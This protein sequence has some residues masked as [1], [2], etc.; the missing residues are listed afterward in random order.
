MPHTTSTIQ[1]VLGEIKIR[2]P[3]FKPKS[4]L[5]YGAG[6]GAGVFAAKEIYPDSL[7]KMGA[8]EPNVYMRKLGK[9]LT[10]PVEPEVMWVDAL[11]MLPGMASA[12]GQ[13]YKFDIIIMAYVLTEIP[14]PSQR[15]IVLET[16]MSRVK[17]NGY[18]VLLE[19]GSPKGFRY[20]HD[21]RNIVR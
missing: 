8:V 20:I 7:N 9:F 5:D 6:L 21:F 18:F 2:D 11:S 4:V 17:D 16:L 12:S 14:T 3:D 1:R 10:K 15:Q 19:Y 13:R